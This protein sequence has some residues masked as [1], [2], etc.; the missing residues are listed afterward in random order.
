[1]ACATA[2]W[3]KAEIN[4]RVEEAARILEL[5]AMLERKPRQLSGGQ[6]QR[7]AMGR[8]I[9]RQPKAFLFDEP[10][11]NLDAKLRIAMRVEIRKLQR[12]AE[13]DLDLRHPRPARGDDARRHSRRDEWRP[14]RADRQPARHLPEAR[15]HLCGLLH[16][17]AADEFDAAAIGRIQIAIRRRSRAQRSRHSRNP[18]R[19]LCDHR[20][21]PSPAASR[22]ISRSRR[23]KGSGPKPS[24]TAHA[25]T[26]TGRRRQPRRPCRRAR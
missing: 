7:V 22:S 1:M 13:H 15:D 9:V 18:S 12:R 3:P 14:G 6:R 5:S 26:P 16:R 21:R 4:T 19:R 20:A 11:S 8:A 10:L 25:S 17:R 2:A 23:S 24:F